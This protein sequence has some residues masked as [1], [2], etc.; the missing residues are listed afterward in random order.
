[1]FY[2][3]DLEVV[4]HSFTYTMQDADAS[5]CV[6]LPCFPD[7]QPLLF[8]IWE[9]MGDVVMTPPIFERDTEHPRRTEVGRGGAA[10]RSSSSTPPSLPLSSL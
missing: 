4:T 7:G 8:G 5:K 10:P 3:L 2:T 6:K 1:M 9:P